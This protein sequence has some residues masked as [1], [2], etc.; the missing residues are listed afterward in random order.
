MT[1]TPLSSAYRPYVPFFPPSFS[2]LFSVRFNGEQHDLNGW[3]KTAI[4]IT[5]LAGVLLA[6]VGV[7]L[8][9]CLSHYLR[10][11]LVDQL[12]AQ[13]GAEKHP[14]FHFD[15]EHFSDTDRETIAPV[16]AG[17]LFYQQKQ[18]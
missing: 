7:L 17:E 15:A 8:R 10:S 4:V 11:K 6:G 14:R 2:D 5:A 3:H 9:F 12:M 18:I 1:T 13:P 16:A